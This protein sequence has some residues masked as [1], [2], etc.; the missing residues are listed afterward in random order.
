MWARESSP[1]I[2]AEKLFQ[3]LLGVCSCD[4][5]AE[6]LSI[7]SVPSIWSLTSTIGSGTGKIWFDRASLE[8]KTYRSMIV[9]TGA[10]KTLAAPAAAASAPILSP[11]FVVFHVEG[12]PDAV[13]SCA[14]GFIMPVMKG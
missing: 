13:G 7:W 12:T 1:K 10:T 9:I 5:R 11:R 8:L 4:N 6:R 14:V 3:R 2:L